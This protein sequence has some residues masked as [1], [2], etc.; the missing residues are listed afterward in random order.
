MLW[1]LL[2]ATSTQVRPDWMAGTLVWPWEFESK[3][4]MMPSLWSATV[5]FVAGVNCT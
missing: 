4:T 1:N 3:A 5:W 2:A